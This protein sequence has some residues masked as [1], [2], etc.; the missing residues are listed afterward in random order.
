MD[1][2]WLRTKQAASGM[3]RPGLCGIPGDPRHKRARKARAQLSSKD[4]LGLT[5]PSR[6][7]HWLAA[8]GPGDAATRQAA[9]ERLSDLTH[10]SEI[11]RLA[12]SLCNHTSIFVQKDT[13]RN[14][15]Q[16]PFHQAWL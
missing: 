10:S 4:E 8:R 2:K 14:A 5:P 3:S 13:P 16:S 15:T 1:L 11:K 7:S 9:W 12:L 6:W